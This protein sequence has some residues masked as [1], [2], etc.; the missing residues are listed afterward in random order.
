MRKAAGIFMIVV[1]MALLA[2]YAGLVFEFGIDFSGL[3][4]GLFIIS[5]PIIIL[6]ALFITGG[7]VCLKREYCRVCFSLALLP[8]VIMFSWVCLSRFSPF[9]AWF[10]FLIPMGIPAIIFV[11]LKRR[12]WQKYQI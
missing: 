9:L 6:P 11:W 3:S 8:V 4:F 7:I 1:G 5:L 12:G 2:L 10:W